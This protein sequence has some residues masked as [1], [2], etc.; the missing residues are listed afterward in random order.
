MT[1]LFYGKLKLE[2]NRE[3]SWNHYNRLWFLLSSSSLWL[4]TYVW[5]KLCSFIYCLFDIGV[6]LSHTHTHEEKSLWLWFL[7][8]SS[9]LWLMTYVWGKLSAFIYF[10]FDIGVNLWYTH[11]RR[12]IIVVMV[13][14]KAV[15]VFGSWHMYEVSFLVS[16]IVCLTFV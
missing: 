3:Q 15:V 13:S 16:S 10:L 5:G 14:P 1:L 2:A 4:M 12:K 7:L 6:N 11:T 8:S 9:S